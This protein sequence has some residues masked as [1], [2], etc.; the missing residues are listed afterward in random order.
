MRTYQSDYS[1][2]GGNYRNCGS[3]YGDRSFTN[4]SA[5]GSCRPTR[6]PPRCLRL[7]HARLLLPGLL[8]GSHVYE[9][10]INSVLFEDDQDVVRLASTHC[11]LSTYAQINRLFKS[12]RKQSNATYSKI[13]RA[14]LAATPENVSGHGLRQNTTSTS[15]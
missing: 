6:N 4:A 13:P 5:T 11:A 7:L 10:P 2:E 8:S 14:E 9:S 15:T 1:F 3:G 12:C